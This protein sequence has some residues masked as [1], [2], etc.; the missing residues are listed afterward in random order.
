[1][2]LKRV[3]TMAMAAVSLL[4]L[5]VPTIVSAAPGD[6]SPHHHGGPRS[7]HGQF[8]KPDSSSDHKALEILIKLIQRTQPGP[9]GD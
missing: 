3:R 4:T 8:S 7:G 1:M 5:A 2:N 9:R 6:G